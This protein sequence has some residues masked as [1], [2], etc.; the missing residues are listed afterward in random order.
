MEVQLRIEVFKPNEAA[1]KRVISQS[2]IT[3]VEVQDLDM[4]DPFECAAKRTLQVRLKSNRE[5][6]PITNLRGVVKIRKP[7]SELSG[8]EVKECF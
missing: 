5:L 8:D 2:P 1:K 4:P 3:Y 7:L 6:S